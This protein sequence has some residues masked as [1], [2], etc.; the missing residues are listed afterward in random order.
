MKRVVI[1]VLVVLAALIAFGEFYI[2]GYGRAL[3][4]AGIVSAHSALKQAYVEY[5]R[6]GSVKPNGSLKPFVF[7]NTVVVDGT[8]FHCVVA[9]AVP[10]FED[11][12]VLA[13][14]TNET[15][16]W[17]DKTRPP[18]IIPPSGYAPHVFPERF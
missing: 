9:V 15:L 14:T 13:M 8:P 2:L 5:S 18:K 3:R 6:Q 11:E 4:L 12:G 10:R 16:V 7:T 1:A 17:L